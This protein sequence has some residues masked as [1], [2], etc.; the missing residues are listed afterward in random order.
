MRGITRKG[1]RGRLQRRAAESAQLRRH[2]APVRHALPLGP[3]R[4]PGGRPSRAHRHATASTAWWLPGTRSAAISRSSSPATS[5][6]PRRRELRAVCAVS[7]VL[8]LEACVRALE[9]PQN[10]LYQWNFVRNLKARMRR[11]ARLFPDRFPLEPLSRIRTVRQFD[12]LYTAPHFG[13]AGATRLLPSRQRPARRRSDPRAGAGPDGGRRSLRPA[14]A[15]L[16][17][18]RSPATRTSPCASRSTAATAP[19]SEHR[20]METTATGRNG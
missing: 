10:A 16:R 12:E 9:R 6:M 15:V 19:S 13:F 3:H 17:P 7:P 11:K 18:R 2:R 5:A 8:D 1:V 4:G 14:G 20:R